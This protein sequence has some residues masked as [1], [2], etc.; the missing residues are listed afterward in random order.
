MLSLCE[1]SILCGEGEHFP[2]QSQVDFSESL[3][4]DWE[5]AEEDRSGS[6]STPFPSIF[7]GSG[8][9]WHLLGWKVL[10]HVGLYPTGQQALCFPSFKSL[11]SATDT[12]KVQWMGELTHLK[13]GPGATPHCAAVGWQ[14]M[15]A[16]FAPGGRGGYQL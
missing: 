15:V 2:F 8:K 14:D 4:C 1:M 11:E 16:V 6:L 5:K 13:Q 3:G 12:S 9:F 7:C 10:A